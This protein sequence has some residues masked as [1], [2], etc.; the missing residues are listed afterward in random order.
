MNEPDADRI[1]GL[2]RAIRAQPRHLLIAAARAARLHEQGALDPAR[3][4]AIV[5]EA[6]AGL[7]EAEDAAALLL[8]PIASYAQAHVAD[9]LACVWPP[10][11]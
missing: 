4:R 2:A 9:A 11:A 5:R 6:A 8:T 10:D 1:A 7:R 3:Q